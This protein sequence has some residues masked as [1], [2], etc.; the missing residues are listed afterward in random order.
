MRAAEDWLPFQVYLRATRDRSLEV[1]VESQSSCSLWHFDEYEDP[2]DPPRRP[3][4][5]FDAN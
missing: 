1:M 3:R 2:V 5:E 4:N